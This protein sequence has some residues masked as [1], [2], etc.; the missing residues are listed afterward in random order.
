[1]TMM[2]NVS[3]AIENKERRIKELERFVCKAPVRRNLRP[4]SEK[5]FERWVT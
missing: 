4:A 2:T 1:M 3:M 5:H